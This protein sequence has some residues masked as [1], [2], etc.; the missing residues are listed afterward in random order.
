MAFNGTVPL[1]AAIG[2][3]EIV[4]HELLQEQHDAL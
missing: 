2:V 3:L 1:A 4:K